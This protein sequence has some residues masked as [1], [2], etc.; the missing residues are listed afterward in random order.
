MNLSNEKP[1]ILVECGAEGTAE[2]IVDPS[3]VIDI[4]V[5]LYSRKVATISHVKGSTLM[6]RNVSKEMLR[7]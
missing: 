1:M 5:R 2:L 3:A 6:D 7:R 4:V